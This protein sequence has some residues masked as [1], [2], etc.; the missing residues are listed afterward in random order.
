MI[1]HNSENKNTINIPD[2]PPMHINM[3]S[4]CVTGTDQ[5]GTLILTEP[6]YTSNEIQTPHNAAQF[7]SLN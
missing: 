3:S 2:S 6:N 4:G 7:N 5:E 1:N